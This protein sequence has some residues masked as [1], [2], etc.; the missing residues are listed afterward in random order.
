MA[1]EIY[2]PN[3]AAEIVLK[4][5][6]NI[7]GL[8]ENYR[9][10]INNLVQAE[11]TK[12]KEEHENKYISEGHQATISN[13]LKILELKNFKI[14]EKQF[15]NL[16]AP[17]VKANDFISLELLGDIMTSKAQYIL[18]E[19]CKEHSKH[20][21]VELK[22]KMLNAIDEYINTDILK[23]V[24]GD[25]LKYRNSSYEEIC[26]LAENLGFEIEDMNKEYGSNNELVN[27]NDFIQ[28]QIDVNL[29]NSV[30]EPLFKF[31]DDPLKENEELII[32]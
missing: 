11:I 13:I 17:L 2:K 31:N 1:K 8:R 4:E 20:N 32:E 19:Y 28:R 9:K 15:E 30:E 26:V 10:S 25:P 16:V 12:I 18:G 3:I 5:I 24:G 22:E 29:G 6:E 27:I 14:E 21:E 7:K 23:A